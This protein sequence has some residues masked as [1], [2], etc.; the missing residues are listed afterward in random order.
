MSTTVYDKLLLSDDRHCAV[1]CVTVTASGT[2]ST[3]DQLSIFHW[4][5][6]LK[7]TPGSSN[8][9]QSVLLDMIPANPPNGIFF[10]PSRSTEGSTARNRVELSVDTVGSPT[11]QQI[12]T[13]FL[14]NKMDRYMFDETSS[15]CLYW[16]QVGLQLIQNAGW[17]EA[18][19]CDGLQ[20][21]Y[22]E[23]ASLHPGRYWV[24]IR[25]G[26]FY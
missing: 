10:I 1:T 24:P 12:I 15:D 18:G 9:T 13:L 22:E 16:T 19:A 8:R 7:L 20:A 25:R 6:Y 26:T 17:V 3:S 23:Q 4:R 21:F 5:L 11:V 2:V 14:N